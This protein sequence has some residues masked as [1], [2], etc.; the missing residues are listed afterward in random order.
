MWREPTNSFKAATPAINQKKEFFFLSQS[1]DQAQN[2]QDNRH[3][4]PEHALL[5][6]GG[7]QVHHA[8]EDEKTKYKP[9]SRSAEG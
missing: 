7:C 6:A 2:Y 9:D 4:R 3:R 1:D 8:A 5:F